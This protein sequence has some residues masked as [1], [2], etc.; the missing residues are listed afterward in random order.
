VFH[1]ITHIHIAQPFTHSKLR[2][3]LSACCG[4][5]RV[6]NS[7]ASVDRAEV[8]ARETE[9]GAD[10]PTP[11]TAHPLFGEILHNIP[12]SV[13]GHV[14]ASKVQKLGLGWGLRVHAQSCPLIHCA[15]THLADVVFKAQGEHSAMEQSLI[16]PH[17]TLTLPLHT[18]TQHKPKG[19]ARS[20]DH[21]LL[22][23]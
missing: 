23:V 9:H 21:A 8:N 15:K 3:G 18:L 17:C 2:L 12:S 4:E 13:R 16:Q 5:L 22:R 11:K 20:C 14:F 6:H 1:F 10:E 19:N 7:R